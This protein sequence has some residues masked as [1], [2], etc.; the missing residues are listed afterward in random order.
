MCVTGTSSTNRNLESTIVT[1]HKNDDDG[2]G[3][4]ASLDVYY[5]WGI[6]IVS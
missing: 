4:F 2:G 3:T 5:L 6:A 1:Q